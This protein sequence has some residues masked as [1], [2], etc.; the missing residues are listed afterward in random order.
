MDPLSRRPRIRFVRR[1]AWALFV[2]AIAGTVAWLVFASILMKRTATNRMTE[3]ERWR[4]TVRFDLSKEPVFPK[5]IDAFWLD[6]P[7][8]GDCAQNWFEADIEPVTGVVGQMRDRTPV[9][10]SRPREDWIKVAL[11]ARFP[12]DPEWVVGTWLVAD[13][14]ARLAAIRKV[15]PE[16]PFGMMP[17]R[18]FDARTARFF[19]LPSHEEAAAL[20]PDEAASSFS[21][22]DPGFELL[23]HVGRLLRLEARHA[24]FAGDGARAIDNLQAIMEISDH[25]LENGTAFAQAFASMFREWAWGEAHALVLAKPDAFDDAQ[26]ARLRSVVTRA[27]DGPIEFDFAGERVGFEEVIDACYT[28]EVQG[29]GHVDGVVVPRAIFSAFSVQGLGGDTE[30]RPEEIGAFLMAPVVWALMPTR[31]ELIAAYDAALAEIEAQL[32]LQ[33]ADRRAWRRTRKSILDPVNSLLGFSTDGI[34]DWSTRIGQTTALRDSACIAIAAER[35]RRAEGR[36]AESIDE[37]VPTYLREVPIDLETGEP[38][39]RLDG[40]EKEAEADPR[41]RSGARSTAR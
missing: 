3:A 1:A 16:T 10:G 19:D 41:K 36:T 5:Y 30:G 25:A 12:A 22:E 17:Q 7:D 31:R 20:S 24:A 26:L 38:R 6:R 39:T 21:L 23:P 37:L 27:G 34:R 40:R 9:E 35:F 14:A 11:E 15:T 32:K 4:R 18:S 33:P 28:Y 29:D 13:S 2:L 8:C